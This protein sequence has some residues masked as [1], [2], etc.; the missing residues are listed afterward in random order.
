MAHTATWLCRP[1]CRHCTGI[2]VAMTGKTYNTPMSTSETAYNGSVRLLT[3]ATQHHHIYLQKDLQDQAN[4]Q[5]MRIWRHLASLIGLT[6]H[7]L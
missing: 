4:S 5:A 7:W 2:R 3:A 1:E 6:A